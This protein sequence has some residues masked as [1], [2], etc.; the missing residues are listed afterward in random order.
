MVL[1]QEIY[2][3]FLEVSYTSTD[4]P[5]KD[6]FAYNFNRSFLYVFP[7]RV[8]GG[9]INFRKDG[10]VNPSPPFL[11]PFPFPLPLSPFPPFFL[12]SLPLE[13]GPP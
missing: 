8:R 2:A 11:L 9:S 5:T 1:S 6:A 13:V 10:G 4:P 7:A 3:N 12:P